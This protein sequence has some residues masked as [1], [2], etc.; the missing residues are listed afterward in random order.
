MSPFVILP[1]RV[2]LGYVLFLRRLVP[3]EKEQDNCLLIKPIVDTVARAVID[4]QLIDSFADRAV[5]AEIAEP[6]A[7]KSNTDLL[8]SGDVPETI[9]PFLERL[10]ARFCEIVLYR[11]RESLHHNNV[12]YKLHLGKGIMISCWSWRRSARTERRRIPASGG[13]SAR[14]KSSR[15]RSVNRSCRFSMRSSEVK[16]RRRRGESGY[17]FQP[18]DVNQQ[19]IVIVVQQ[20]LIQHSE[21]RPSKFHQAHRVS[22]CHFWI[23]ENL[24]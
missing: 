12:A 17:T 13:G 4:L 16:R 19:V 9:K 18:A 6:N 1:V 14:W 15:R 2:R 20:H 5:L 24:S 22:F 10:P 7:V 11:V 21:Y 3:A 8:P 23:Y